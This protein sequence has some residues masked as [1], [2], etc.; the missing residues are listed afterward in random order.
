VVAID[1]GEGEGEGG[2]A[3]RAKPLDGVGVDGSL[4]TFDVDTDLDGAAGDGSATGAIGGSGDDASG[5]KGV[6]EAV[7]FARTTGASATW[8]SPFLFA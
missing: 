6:G 1:E 8:L 4:G 5:E 7:A 2:C 3:D